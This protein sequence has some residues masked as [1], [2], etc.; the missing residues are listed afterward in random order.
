[1]TGAHIPAEYKQVSNPLDSIRTH[2]YNLYSS[3]IKD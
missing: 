2:E 3:I 1:M